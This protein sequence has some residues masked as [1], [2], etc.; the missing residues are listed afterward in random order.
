VNVDSGEWVGVLRSARGSVEAFSDV[1]G[2]GKA[3]LRNSVWA[4]RQPHWLP[5]LLYCVLSRVLPH[6]PAVCQLACYIHVRLSSK[7]VSNTLA[8]IARSRRAR[9]GLLMLKR[10]GTR[11]LGSEHTCACRV[12]SMIHVQARRTVHTEYLCRWDTVHVP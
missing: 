3:G 1:P 11:A 2:R 5:R 7:A 9:L 12:P 4:R 8:R 10:A 6:A